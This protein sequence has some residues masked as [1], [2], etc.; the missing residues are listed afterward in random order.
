MKI[1]FN[2]KTIEDILFMV[3]CILTIINSIVLGW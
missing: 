1:D 2:K 3:M